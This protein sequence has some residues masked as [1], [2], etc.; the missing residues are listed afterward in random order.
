[1]TLQAVEIPETKKSIVEISY[2]SKL[3]YERL[4]T[5]EVNGF[6]S[7][8]DLSELIGR[9]VQQYRSHLTTAIR[10]CLSADSIVIEAVRNEGVKRLADG[11]IL[12]IPKRVRDHIRKG[13]RRGIKK[14]STVNYDTL[15][16]E[17]QVSHNA[18]WSILGTLVHCTTSRIHKKIEAKVEE[19]QKRLPI[20][21]T[22]EIFK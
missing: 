17:Q 2:E 13:C 12:K 7:Y 15:T 1:M 21:K 14:I 5:L 4:K 9:N 10:K 20:G 3:L 16:R 22:L 19:A 8:A 6:V 18:E 11:D